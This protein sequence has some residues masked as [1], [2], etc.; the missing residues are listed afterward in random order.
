M[1]YEAWGKIFYQLNFV[2]NPERDLEGKEIWFIRQDLLST[3][4]QIQTK[5]LENRQITLLII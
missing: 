2:L 3:G 4:S 5:C 1:S